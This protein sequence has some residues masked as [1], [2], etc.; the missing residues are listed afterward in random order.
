M[1][2]N[3]RNQI[4]LGGEF[5]LSSFAKS[6]LVL[7]KADPSPGAI[8]F[9]SGRDAIRALLTIFPKRKILASSYSC[10]TVISALGWSNGDNLKLLAI[11]STMYPDPQLIKEQLLS[12]AG[13]YSNALFFLGNLW[14][15]PYPLELISFLKLFRDG[16]GIVVEDITHKFD[17]GPMAEVDGWI[18]SVRKWFGTS[19][20]ATLNL[21]QHGFNADQENLRVAPR[22]T[23]RLILMK[24]LNYFPRQSIL[25]RQIIER[26]RESD[27]ALGR[28]NLISL[29]SAHEIER[30]EHQD[31]QQIFSARIRNKKVYEQQ[32]KQSSLVQILNPTTENLS[33]FPTTVKIST[34]NKGLRAFLRSKNIFAANLW[35][36]GQW[37]IAHPGAT[38]LSHLTLTLPS[39]QRFNSGSCAQVADI[40]NQYQKTDLPSE[41]I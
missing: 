24:S 8:Y 37:S 36:L 35:P 7:D 30:F 4:A 32:L 2:T 9:E 31:W 15:T 25:R 34:G 20:L 12:Q 10:E 29:A 27:A 6:S 13:D 3:H 33:S 26:L 19:G 41:I 39:D 18:C 21:C 14:G 28:S 22:V 16:G 40:V 23:G 17:L 1:A 5:S 11:D 38:S